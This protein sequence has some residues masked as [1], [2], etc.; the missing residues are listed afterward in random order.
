MRR[1]IL[2]GETVAS[3]RQRPLN[4]IAASQYKKFAAAGILRI[5]SLE[6]AFSSGL[7][8]PEGLCY[9]GGWP[10]DPRGILF[11]IYLSF[12]SHPKYKNGDL[13]GFAPR[14]MDRMHIPFINGKAGAVG[15][16]AGGE[17]GILRKRGAAYGAE[18]IAI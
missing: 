18:F 3:A 2:K 14:R 5:A 12:W 11:S 7:V 15:T 17:R 8:L 13:R 10:K 9:S 16:I 4:P 1:R 6:N